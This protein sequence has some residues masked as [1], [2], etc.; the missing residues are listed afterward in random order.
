[1]NLKDRVI[2]EPELSA[3]D[4]LWTLIKAKREEPGIRTE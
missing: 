3:G 2:T 4:V 1:M